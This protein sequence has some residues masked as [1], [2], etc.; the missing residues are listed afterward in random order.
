MNKW[1]PLTGIVTYAPPGEL[2]KGLAGSGGW[3][4][5]RLYIDELR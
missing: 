5:M 1:V 4:S 3:V 2:L